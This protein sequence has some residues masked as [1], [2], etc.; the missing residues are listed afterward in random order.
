MKEQ[1]IISEP[2]LAARRLE[3]Q[4]VHTALDDRQNSAALGK[5]DGADELCGAIQRDIP[6][7]SPKPGVFDTA[8]FGQELSVI[9]VVCGPIARK[10]RRIDTGRA[11]ERVDT[12]SGVVCK[13]QAVCIGAVMKRLL[14]GVVL[15]CQAIFD[16]FRDFAYARNRLDR[17]AAQLRGLSEF[18]ELAGI[19]RGEIKN[20][21]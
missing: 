17:D 14:A 12:K 4:P 19:C 2:A 5:G 15:E 16:A 7:G 1:G 10:P 8:Q 6:L 21:V 9:L 18:C 11:T 3:N 20:Q 13:N